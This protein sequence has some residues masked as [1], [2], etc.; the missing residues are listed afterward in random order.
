M[1]KSAYRE[2]M[3]LKRFSYLFAS[4]VFITW[5]RLQKYQDNFE[6]VREILKIFEMFRY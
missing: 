5:K 1:K 6:N 4:F 3:N 2:L